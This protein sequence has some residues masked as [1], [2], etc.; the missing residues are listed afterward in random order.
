MVDTVTLTWDPPSTIGE[1]DFYQISYKD[2]S[3]EGNWE[4]YQ[5]EFKSSTAV[6]SDLKSNT[7]FVFRVRVVNEDDADLYS[8]Q[9]D[10]IVTL[11]SQASR[12]VQASALIEKGNPSP[13]KY[14]L[15]LSEIR[16][17]RNEQAKTTKFQLG[18]YL[19]LLSLSVMFKLSLVSV[20]LYI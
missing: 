15:P 16:E 17:A 1:N 6:L 13:S 2:G 19:H 20:F 18:I 7:V 9:S 10:K 4:I 8:E 11:E 12:H 3:H 5:G 14:A